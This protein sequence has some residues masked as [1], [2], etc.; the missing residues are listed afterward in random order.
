MGG[1]QYQAKHIVES[2][3]RRERVDVH[4]LAPIIP[5]EGLWEGCYLH[6]VRG[7]RHLR[8][9]AHAFDAP[10]IAWIL[11]KL[12]PEVVYQR[13][14]SGHSGISGLCAKLHNAYFVWHISN[15]QEFAPGFRGSLWR[16]PHRWIELRLID[17]AAKCADCIVVQSDD[18]AQEMVARYGR[19]PEMLV[20]N[21]MPAP[22]PFVK[23]RS[24]IRIVWVANW[25]RG[26]RPEL[27]VQLAE[28]LS[29]AVNARFVMIGSR[30][31]EE[32]WQSELYARAQKCASLEIPGQLSQERVNEELANAHLLVNT[33]D[34]EG[35]SNVYIQAWQRGVPVVA[36]HSD[37][38]SVLKTQGLGFCADGRVDNL[39]QE[40]IRLATDDGMREAMGG[41]CMEYALRNHDLSSLEPLVERL[42]GEALARAGSK[43][44][45]T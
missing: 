26:K 5:R 13:S 43:R 37:P 42:E 24:P 32:S 39:H 19:K 45:E 22:E 28:Q 20:R 15:M 23:P 35:F 16:R 29:G 6:R 38:D 31:L 7:S 33:S 8:K 36:L 3:L 1:A 41:R 27:F 21:A 17:V 34:F 10:S 9:Y 12:R 25:K 4:Y 30:N 14:A 40:L 11:R 18:Q 44:A 2:L